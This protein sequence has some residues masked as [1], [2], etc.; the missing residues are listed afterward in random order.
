MVIMIEVVVLTLCKF[1][2]TLNIVFGKRLLLSAVVE[3]WFSVL[4]IFFYVSP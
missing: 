4:H 1:G 2:Q 3:D